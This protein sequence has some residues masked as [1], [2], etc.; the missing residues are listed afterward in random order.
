M[1][2]SGPYKG[3]EFCVQEELGKRSDPGFQLNWC[4]ESATNQQ[5]DYFNGNFHLRAHGGCLA[6][7][8]VGMFAPLS[9]RNCDDAWTR[10]DVD[11]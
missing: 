7:E 11:N 6:P 3:Q 5:F 2:P 9:Y 10:W 4:S 1:A 8:Y